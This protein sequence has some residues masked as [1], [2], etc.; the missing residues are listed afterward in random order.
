MSDDDE[1][2]YE[3][4]LGRYELMKTALKRMIEANRLYVSRMNASGT[5]SELQAS[6]A[7]E[8][9]RSYQ[10]ITADWHAA[11]DRLDAEHGYDSCPDPSRTE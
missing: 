7:R 4:L 2:S 5:V 11:L 6:I 3:H 1:A 9:E 10:Q 8:C